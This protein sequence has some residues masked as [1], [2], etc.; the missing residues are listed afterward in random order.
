MNHE[1]EDAPVLVPCKHCRFSDELNAEGYCL[2]CSQTA[3]PTQ[4][5]APSASVGAGE[6]V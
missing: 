4:G 3:Q 5:G 1:D 2:L 6:D